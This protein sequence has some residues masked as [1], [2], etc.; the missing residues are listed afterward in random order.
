MIIIPQQDETINFCP[1]TG[2]AITSVETHTQ[3]L[4]DGRQIVQLGKHNKSIEHE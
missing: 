3:V 1:I 2:Q 4:Y